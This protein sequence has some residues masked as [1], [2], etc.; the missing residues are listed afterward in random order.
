M[1]SSLFSRKIKIFLS[2]SKLNFF[3]FVCVS[4]INQ[5]YLTFN[6]Y[7]KWKQTN[8]ICTGIKFKFF[9]FVFQSLQI[10]F[11]LSMELKIEV[12]QD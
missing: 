9:G 1:G 4:N 10:N 7:R 12:K 3:F 11:T 8:S 6:I 2:F 5:A